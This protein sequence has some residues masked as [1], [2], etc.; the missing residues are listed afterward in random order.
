MRTERVIIRACFMDCQ[1]PL[2]EHQ[3]SA[4]I[5][6]LAD[7][8]LQAHVQSCPACAARV[9]RARRFERELVHRFYRWDCPEAR[10]LVEYHLQLL[11]L[12]LFRQMTAHLAMCPRCTAELVQVRRWSA[13]DP[14]AADTDLPTPS[15]LPSPRRH[16]QTLRLLP[17]EQATL[18]RSNEPR[19]AE[20]EGV[21]MV[22]ELQTTPLGLLMINGQLIIDD[23]AAW[24]GALLELR[25]ADQLRA[26]ALLD[27]E[28]RWSCGP[29][30]DLPVE[31]RITNELGHVIVLHPSD[32]RL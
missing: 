6:G 7:S 25:Q 20:A 21:H 27:E 29:L 23:Q 32:L 18:L 19:F 17:R 12:E 14:P 3:I 26:T 8:T 4:L 22:F 9:E 1:T 2:T 31:L 24:M 15:A 13:A 28:G 5:D 16:E 30:P 10:F 11:D